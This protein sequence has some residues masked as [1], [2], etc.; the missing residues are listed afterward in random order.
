LTVPKLEKQVGIEVYATKSPS[1]GGVIRRSIKDFVVEE[2]L[3]DSSK[4]SIESSVKQSVLG[5]SQTKNRYLLCILVKRN[6]DTISAVEAVADQLDVSEKQVQTA[7]LKDARAVTAQHI[8]IEDVC[9][10]DAQKVHVKDIEIRSVGYFRSKL[11]SYYLLGNSFRIAI[12]SIKASKSTIEKRVAQTVEELRMIG[13]IPNFF[14]HQRFGTIRP[15]THQVGK[16]I[17][18]GDFGKAAMLFLAKPS[19]YEHPASRQARE[20][21]HRT[22]DFK[23]A[24]QSFPK[25]LRYERL[26]LKHLVGRPDDYVGAFSRLPMKL[27]ELFPQAYQSY[28]FNRFLSRRIERGLPLDRA[29]IGDYV[30]CV[31]RSGLPMVRMNKI[32]TAE[33]LVEINNAIQNG[34]MRLAIPLV[35]FKQYPSLGIQGEIEKQILEEEGVIAG[36]FKIA[37][38][39]KISLRGELRTTLTPLNDF[40]IEEIA[41]DSVDLSK[42]EAVVSFTLYRSSYA[43]ILLRE[44]MKPRDLIK[45][46]F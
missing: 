14:G 1:I 24:L 13:G 9:T 11:S 29:E 38:I 40:S 19:P 8:T 28:L 7:G 20:T 18:K 33:N 39:P 32:V 41:N 15:I 42:H 21:L 16:A 44:L 23:E 4:A 34:K 5:S 30:V 35:G 12:S 10:E 25:Q 36:N 45:A 27:Q 37:A 17:V 31:E 26:V 43:T 46:G 6:W 3:V 22:R 2:V